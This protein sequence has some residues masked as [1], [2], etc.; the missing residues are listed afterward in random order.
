MTPST[1]DHLRRLGATDEELELVGRVGTA[2]DPGLLGTWIER[3]HGA[4]GAG[5]SMGH[6]LDT[7]ALDAVDDPEQRGVLRGALDRLELVSIGRSIGSGTT[8]LL[9]RSG[10][11]SD[12]DAVLAITGLLA[13]LHAPA[14]DDRG[15]GA[16]LHEAADRALGLSVWTLDE[17]LARVALVVDEP[18]TSLLVHLA[19]QGGWGDGATRAAALLGTADVE[20]PAR[21]EWSI[22]ADGAGLALTVD[23]ADRI[24]ELD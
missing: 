15:F 24:P 13:A 10:P 17:G 12:D 6:G 3:R 22:D 7:A 18:S 23:I 1:L 19:M 21:L 8:R 20:H 16:L 4:L 5:W 9:L 11:A 14:F 2:A